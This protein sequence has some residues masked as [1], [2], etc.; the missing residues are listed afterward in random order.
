M[1]TF[2][3]DT[4]T[5]TLLLATLFTGLLAGI[6][7]TWGNAVTPGIGKL[8]DINYLR[9]F[10]NMNRTIQNPLFFLVFFGSLLFSF[11][12]AYFH[13]SNTIILSLTISA[14][15]IYF[16]GVILVTIL[17]NIPLNEMLDKTDLVHTSIQEAALLRSKFEAKWNN[18][19][20]FRIVASIIS[21]LLLI[22]S[23]LLKTK[24]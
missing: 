12:A 1:E 7:L 18:L 14:A 8:D 24:P 13:K 3:V 17:G 21:F 16:T 22:I 10:Q 11:A 19:H 15:I 2:I 9:A 5:I 4:K 23:C 20:L 6:F